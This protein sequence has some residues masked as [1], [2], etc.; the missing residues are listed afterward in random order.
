M[1]KIDLVYAKM[2]YS[3]QDLMFSAYGAY[4]RW[5]RLGGNFLSLVDEFVKRESYSR[6]D[7]QDY[8]I[9]QLKKILKI[10]VEHV[11]Y[12]RSTWTDDQKQAAYEGQ[13]SNLP[14]LEKTHLRDNAKNFIQHQKPSGLNFSFHTSGTTGTPI[15]SNFTLKE[16]RTSMAVREARSANWADVSFKLPRATFS[17]RLVVPDPEETKRIYRYNA[18]ERQLYFSPFHLQSETAKYY[19]NGLQKYNTH[20]ITGYAVSIYLLAKYA[21]DQKLEVP[22]LRAVITTSEK[23]TASMRE[24]I[25]RVFQCGV[26]EEYSTVESALFA[27]ECECGRLHLSPDIGYVEILDREGNPCQ[28]GE[29]GEIVATCLFRHYQPLVRFRLGDLAAWDDQPCKC[30]R[31]MPVLKEVVGRIEDLVTTQ[32]GRQLVRFH[33]LFVDQPNVVEGQVIQETLNDFVI[34][35]VGTDSFDKQDE[36]EIRKRMQQ[37]LGFGV[38]VQIDKVNLIPRTAAGKF[39]AVISKVKPLD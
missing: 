22:K 13:L 17:G 24:V 32:D 20:W 29:V 10:C 21:F 37:R 38:N 1:H 3:V 23:L 26:F 39:K 7:W 30:G 16:L 35:V 27:S 19:I 31:A 6:M 12:Y 2:P 34:K 11:P 9:S 25:A 14:A 28:P 4:W 5:A 18:A 33:G 36:Q 8:Q 15:E